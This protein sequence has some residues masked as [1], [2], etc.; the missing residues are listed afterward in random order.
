MFNDHGC[1]F[2]YF[3]M[4]RVCVTD[5]K[6]SPG[7]PTAFETA[8]FLAVAFLV[9][10]ILYSAFVNAFPSKCK[11]VI[12]ARQVSVKRFTCSRCHQPWP[13]FVDIHLVFGDW[14]WRGWRAVNYCIFFYSC[15]HF[16]SWI[17]WWRLLTSVIRSTRRGFSETMGPKVL[18]SDFNLILILTVRSWRKFH[19][20][21][22]DV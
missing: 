1:G 15:A 7:P 14:C 19:R 16:N 3:M 21:Q 4:P 8:P 22:G 12:E 9:L 11:T 20:M 5:K 17:A 10:K 18:A 6:V 13:I 2:G